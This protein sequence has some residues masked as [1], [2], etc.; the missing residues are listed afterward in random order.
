MGANRKQLDGNSTWWH[1]GGC[2]LNRG[3]ARAPARKGGA[4]A[5][6]QTTSGATPKSIGQRARTGAL[7]QPIRSGEPAPRSEWV[8]SWA[9][10]AQLAPKVPLG[11]QAQHLARLI[12]AGAHGAA[13]SAAEGAAFQQQPAVLRLAQGGGC[14]LTCA[15][16]P[17]AEEGGV[18]GLGDQWDRVQWCRPRLLV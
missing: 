17:G 18:A 4:R 10:Q 6:N 14:G 12:T 5:A 2:N 3:C 11:C 13:A 8:A 7:P 9:R 15:D 16:A 1:G